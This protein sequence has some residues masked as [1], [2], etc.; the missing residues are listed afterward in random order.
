M[1][2]INQLPKITPQHTLTNVLLIYIK[3]YAS[4]QSYIVNGYGL[5]GESIERIYITCEFFTR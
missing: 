2:T 1:R 4:Y 3:T 5:W